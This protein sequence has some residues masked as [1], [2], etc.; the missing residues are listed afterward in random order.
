MA[1]RRVPALVV[2]PFRVAGF[3]DAQGLCVESWACGMESQALRRFGGHC[4]EM[5][6]ARQALRR[7]PLWKSATSSQV[8]SVS[9]QWAV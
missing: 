4:M 9:I 6:S 3:S 5:S 8:S 7:F 2:D 1:V